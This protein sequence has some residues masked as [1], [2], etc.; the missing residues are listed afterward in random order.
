MTVGQL[1]V[2]RR[3]RVVDHYRRPDA[4]TPETELK[5]TRVLGLVKLLLAGV[6]DNL[7]NQINN[8]H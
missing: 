1:S 2:D 3:Q 7:Q 5:N 6:D 8:N 4:E